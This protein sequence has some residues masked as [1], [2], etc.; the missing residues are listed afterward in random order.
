MSSCHDPEKAPA[1]GGGLPGQLA[2]TLPNMIVS[3]AVICALMAAALAGVYLLTKPAI[4]QTAKLREAEAVT[5]VL[6]AFDSH[7]AQDVRWFDRNGV[8]LDKNLPDNAVKALLRSYPAS[9][10]GK[11]V[12]LAVR[13]FS[14]RGYGKRIVVMVGFLP[15]GGINKV[16]V[17]EQGETAGFGSKMLESPFADQFPG[18]N[19]ASFKLKVKKDGGDVDAIS[20]ATIS[21]RAYCDALDQAVKIFRE[22]T[23]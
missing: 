19:P 10:G 2:S 1:H 3:L 17:M 8:E 21:S 22:V 4:D 5:N 7:P 18:K 12:G 23:Q 14:D 13:T 6:P 9:Q 20:G 15:D 11:P 16:Q